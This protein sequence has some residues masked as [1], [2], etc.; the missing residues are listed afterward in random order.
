MP[1]PPLSLCEV[2]VLLPLDLALQPK[3]R[4][5]VLQNNVY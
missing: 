1:C 3:Q 2:I 4:T 5:V